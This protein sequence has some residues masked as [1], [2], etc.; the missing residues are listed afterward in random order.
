MLTIFYDL[1]E[2]I[3]EVIVD[4]FFLFGDSFNL[5]LSNLEK[6]L[7]INEEANLVLK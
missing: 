1:V 4:D 7:K 5:C 2:D 3:I 6:V